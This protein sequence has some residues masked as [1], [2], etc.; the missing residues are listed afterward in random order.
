MQLT[1]LL[2]WSTLFNVNARAD[3]DEIRFFL[4]GSGY[5]DVKSK[6]ANY[7]YFRVTFCLL[8]SAVHFSILSFGLHLFLLGCTLAYTRPGVGDE[9]I[10]IH[11]FAGDLIVLPAGIYTILMPFGSLTQFFFCP[12]LPI[13]SILLHTEYNMVCS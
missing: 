11:C 10:R 5:F 1:A 4:K 8:L 6:G 13:C 2:V 9:Y 12:L 3:D 7:Y